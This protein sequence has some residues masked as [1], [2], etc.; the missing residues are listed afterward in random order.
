MH[1]IM[2]NSGCNIYVYGLLQVKHHKDMQFN[3][4]KF[5]IKKLD[6]TK[7]NSD[8]GIN[9]VF[10][11]TNVSYRIDRHP[12]ILEN[13]YYGYLED[14]VQCDFNS[15]KLVLFVS[16]WYRLLLNQRD[17]ATTIIECDNGLTMVNTRNLERASELYVLPHQ[18]EHVFYSTVLVRGG[19][20]YVVRY[21]PRGRSIKYIVAKEEDIEE[22]DDVE[23]QLVH[24][25]DKDIE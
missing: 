2:I 13:R 6:E 14:I 8:C 12:K 25:L 24:E 1:L 17:P 19:W 4:R 11:V 18:C 23:E 9:A 16:K 3:G 20:L 22:E 10:E 15:F 7:K 21:D 5:L